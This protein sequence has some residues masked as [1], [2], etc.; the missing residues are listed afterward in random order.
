MKG[1]S[2]SSGPLPLLR[3]HS[4]PSRS[5]RRLLSRTGHL[6]RLASAG[7]IMRVPVDILTSEYAFSLAPD[8]WNYF[9]ALVAEYDERPGVSIEET[10]FFRFFQHKQ[11]RSVKYLND[12]LFLHDSANGSRKKQSK[13]HF[14]TY[15]W[16]SWNRDLSV[17]GGRPWGRH[18]D[19]V[20]RKSTR[21][22][23]GYRRNPWYIPG[24]RY[25]LEIEWNHTIQLL[26]SISKGYRP[27][28]HGSFPTVTM[29]V[30][31]D[32]DRRA[33][34][35][36]GHHRLSILAH[37]GRERLHVL[38][39][40]DSI[41]TIHESDVANWHYVKQGYCT[42]EDALQIFHA[43]FNLNGRE[44]IEFLGLPSVY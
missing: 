44:R 13:F 5:W 10:T 7:R 40:Y 6:L 4:A 28:R 17:V 26:H 2:V 1:H 20:E 19:H 41:G 37:Q 38:I 43:Y 3:R 8:G 18:Y 11:I 32:G 16:G 39:P 30:R 31:D 9:R 36:D 23:F 24:D 21:D 33:V 29:L 14:G 15:P 42:A 22:L 25:A 34:R 27:L 12:V 35:Y